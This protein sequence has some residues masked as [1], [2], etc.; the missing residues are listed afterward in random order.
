MKRALFSIIMAGCLCGLVLAQ[1]S[2][3]GQ[4]LYDEGK[5]SSAEAEFLRAGDNDPTA[6]YNAGNAVYQQRQ[7]ERAAQLFLKAASMPSEVRA[8]ALYNAG[9][10]YL[11]LG[12][13]AEAI[14]AYRRSLRLQPAQPDAKQNL[15]IAQNLLQPEAPPPP[16]SPPPPPPPPPGPFLDP[17]RPYRPPEVPRTLSEAEAKKWLQKVVEQEEGKY[18]RQYRSL[19]P[20]NETNRRQKG[21]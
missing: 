5:Y 1:T 7:Y 14:E 18:A 15:Q 12:K 4:Q 3:T 20:R 13:Y 6:L 16:P 9:N 17:P 21:W 11:R 8:D 10:A 2:R 19:P